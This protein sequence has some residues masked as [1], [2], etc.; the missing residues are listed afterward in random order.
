M[1]TSDTL[2]LPASSTAL[3][4]GALMR[5]AR[6]H[7]V[8]QPF[9]VDVIDRPAP[10]P[11][12]VLVRVETCGLVQNFA[13]I[14]EF[15][16]PELGRPD[17]PAVYGLDAVGVVAAVGSRVHGLEVGERVYVNP[18][19]GC[20]NC[21]HCRKGSIEGCDFLALNGYLG[22]GSRSSELMKDHPYGGLAEYITAPPSSLVRL[23]D[24]IS[25]ELAA[26]WGYLGT[27]YAALQRGGASSG[28]T[29]L[30][31]GATGTLGVGV[32]AFALG[33]GVSKIL[34]VGR[35]TQ[36]LERVRAL[37]PDRVHTF[38]TTEDDGTIAEWAHSLTG[39][40]GADLVIDALPSATPGEAFMAGFA[41][42]GRAGTLVNTG[43]VLD[44]VPINAFNLMNNAQTL[45][46]SFWFST[47]QGQEMADLVGDGS[48]NL[49][50]FEHRVYPLGEVN[51]ALASIAEHHTGFANYVIS[52]E[53]PPT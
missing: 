52:H 20:G 24:S 17:F 32:V 33:M 39:G 2:D 22:S 10:G 1:S 43:G 34:A 13:Y 49:G 6:Y 48:V 27:G 35:R 44:D 26:R 47:Q 8:G 30:V 9:S 7:A 5:A 28:T 4:N 14:L 15:L 40:A 53:H 31:N 41:A 38:S 19:R 25:F 29:L 23:P 3:N 16:P 11:D 18:M 46:G 45:T 51:E 42:L 50:F 21:R 37:A 12:D 36:L